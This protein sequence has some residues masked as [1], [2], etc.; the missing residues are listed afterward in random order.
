MK[1]RGAFDLSRC[2]SNTPIVITKP[3]FLDADPRF[4]QGV[5]FLNGKANRELHDLWVDVEPVR[6]NTAFPS[7]KA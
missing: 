4:A 6:L 3:Y 1:Y 5:Q 7:T 2:E